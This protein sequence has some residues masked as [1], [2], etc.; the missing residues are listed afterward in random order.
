MVF[1]TTLVGALLGTFPM[2]GTGRAAPVYPISP[3]PLRMLVEESEFILTAS[4]RFPNGEVSPSDTRFPEIDEALRGLTIPAGVAPERVILEV[5]QILKGDPGTRAIEQ[6]NSKMVCP[7]PA[8]YLVGTR[9]LAFLDRNK[10]STGF[11]TH[12]LSYGSKTLDEDGLKIYIQRVTEQLAILS[13][14]LNERRANQ[15][16]WLVKCAEHP[17]TC[18]E[19]AYELAPAGDFMSEFDEQRG[20]ANA[21]ASGLSEEQRARLYNALLA[22]TSFGPGERCLD[23]LF[24]QDEDPRLLAWLVSQL[25]ANA[26]EVERESYGVAWMLI[27]RIARRDSRRE[28]QEL[29]RAFE[30][31]QTFEFWKKEDARNAPERLRIVRDLLKLY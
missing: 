29:V 4:V 1:L 24:N 17:T 8:E 12:A 16:E 5:D 30:Q 25:R 6:L 18:W 20:S 15:I 11:K 13:M 10:K 19:G 22:A 21:F 7:A 27:Q 9:V 31:R 14:P 23:E 2:P 3:R 26:G 28:V